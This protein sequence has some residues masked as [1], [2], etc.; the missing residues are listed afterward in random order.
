MEEEYNPET[1]RMRHEFEGERIKRLEE[2]L[3]RIFEK[4]EKFGQRP[5]WIVA[6]VLSFLASGLGISITIILNGGPK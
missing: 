1:C 3:P 2:T 5:S 6:A 4:L